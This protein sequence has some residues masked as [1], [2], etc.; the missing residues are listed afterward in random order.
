MFERNVGGDDRR[1]RAVLAVVFA[2][3]AAWGLL[4][5]RRPLAVVAGLTALGTGFN[6]VVCWCGVN[7]ALGLDTTR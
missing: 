7:E 2:V 4:E 3:A 1:L 6:A 5:G